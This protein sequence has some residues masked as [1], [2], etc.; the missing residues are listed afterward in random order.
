MRYH[1]ASPPS[2]PHVAATSTE[3]MVRIPGG[4]FRM[5]SEDF[6]PE[7]RPL[8]EVQVSALW[9]DAHPVTNAEF[10]RFVHATV[11]ATVVSRPPLSPDR[12]I[13]AA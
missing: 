13:W 8:R 3:Q 7:E 6:Y 9:V 2:V 4:R 11:P 10:R 1:G 5:G 12:L